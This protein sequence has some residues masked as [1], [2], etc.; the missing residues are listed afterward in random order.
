MEKCKFPDGIT[1]RPDGVNEL[2]PCVYE[3]VERYRNV[4]V[5]VMRCKHCGHVE[6]SWFRQEDIE[7]VTE[8]ELSEG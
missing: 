6:I 4:T 7:E 2:D 1:I 8:D 5:S 3:E